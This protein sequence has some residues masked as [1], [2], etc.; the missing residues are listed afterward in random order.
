[1]YSCDAMKRNRKA[2]GLT[3]SIVLMLGLV[4]VFIG[5]TFTSGIGERLKDMFGATPK[6]TMDDSIYSA[7]CLRLC[8]TE[9]DLYACTASPDGSNELCGAILTRIKEAEGD[10]PGEPTSDIG[11]IKLDGD[12]LPCSEMSVIFKNIVAE[13]IIDFSV[14]IKSDNDI[15]V[16]V[17]DAGGAV[18]VPV[19]D[20]YLLCSSA[21]T[22]CTQ[23]IEFKLPC[24]YKPEVEKFKP[25]IKHTISFKSANAAGDVDDTLKLAQYKDKKWSCLYYASF[26][27]GISFNQIVTNPLATTRVT[28]KK[29]II[30]GSQTHMIA[31][32]KITKEA[33]SGPCEQ[34]SSP[35]DAP[36]VIS[37]CM[38]VIGDPLGLK[39]VDPDGYHFTMPRVTGVLEDIRFIIHLTVK[40]L[41]ETPAGD[42]AICA[43]KTTASMTCRNKVAYLCYVDADDGKE[44]ILSDLSD[45]GTYT[46]DGVCKYTDQ[47]EYENGCVKVSDGS[48]TGDL[49]AACTLPDKIYREDTMIEDVNNDECKVTDLEIVNIHPCKVADCDKDTYF[50]RADADGWIA[51]DLKNNGNK[52]I[53][54]HEGNMYLTIDGNAETVLALP[55][56]TIPAGETIKI[57]DTT[58]DTIKPGAFLVEGTYTVEAR[59]DNLDT[60]KYPVVD[61]SS[62]NTNNIRTETI[63]VYPQ[64][65]EDCVV[66]PETICE[67]KCSEICKWDM[68]QIGEDKCMKK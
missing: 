51:V 54:F 56:Y 40:K 22:P 38:L 2:F 31:K 42:I 25:D 50:T 29:E 61:K 37:E 4:V 43:T 39:Y 45:S 64:C 6:G 7:E 5:V 3:E 44:Y 20:D 46:R 35:I 12:F 10:L 30:S 48:H 17:R 59:I 18:I 26:P 53:G 19:G 41:D 34:P 28:F 21:T 8:D 63:T 65:C 67:P 68:N 49:E 66:C 36:I 9:Y 13:E 24:D 55:S 33:S 14:N 57:I 32:T 58:I 60:L 47:T 16:P 15:I 11:T 52:D 27:D 1:M 62:R 23:E